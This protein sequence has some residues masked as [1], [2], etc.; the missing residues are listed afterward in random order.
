MSFTVV[1]LCNLSIP[2]GTRIPFGADFTLQ[3]LP[4]WVKEDGEILA[5]ISGS[6]RRLVGEAS[7]ALVAEYE[8]DAIG[9]P[10]PKWPGDNPKSI[11]ELKF[12]SAM[13]ANLA[14][15]L[16]QP[17]PVYFTVVFHA[18][19]RLASG[20]VARPPIIL[21][22]QWHTP[23]FCLP[24]F[25]SNPIKPHHLRKAGEIH[26]IVSTVPRGNVVWAALRAFWSALTSRPVD[27]RYPL[28]WQGL[29]SL[30]ASETKA[31]KVTEL[32]C[33]RISFFLA[34][35]AGDQQ[36]LFRKVETCYETRSK[37]V[38]GRWKPGPGI[39]RQ[40]ADTENICRTAMRHILE[41]PAMVDAFISPR[42]DDF[43]DAWVQSGTFTPPPPF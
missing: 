32:L 34:D 41:K 33:N 24:E 10:D 25:V 2:L 9:L 18:L 3:E 43:L 38:H 15:W 6:D 42:R 37:I 27:L 17:C 16:S 8:A 35:N 7:S 4:P 30:F 26:R 5:G 12:Q 36:A 14:I 31:W 21:Q 40:M 19:T 20:E 23:M 22:T 39:D 29:E 1:P 28:F 13:L 11:Q